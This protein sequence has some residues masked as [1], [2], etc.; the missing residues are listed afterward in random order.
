[1]KIK[2]LGTGCSKCR[3][4]EENLETALLEL[5][6][7]TEVSSEGKLAEIVRYG[8]M[9]TPALVIDEKV[10][11]AGGKALSVE[12]LKALILEQ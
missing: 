5:G 2:I 7:D 10:V 8:V 6:L 3:I 12:E 11:Y 9:I 1:M 4:I